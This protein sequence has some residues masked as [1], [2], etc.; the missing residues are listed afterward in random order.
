MYVNIY[1][2]CLSVYIFFYDLSAD[3]NNP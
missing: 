3:D 2:G 1:P